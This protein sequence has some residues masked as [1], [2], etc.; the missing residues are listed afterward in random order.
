MGVVEGNFSAEGGAHSNAMRISNDRGGK[1]KY[2]VL[3]FVGP[4]VFG[5]VMTVFFGAGHPILL[6]VLFCLSV[7]L[8]FICYRKRVRESASEVEILGDSLFYTREGQQHEVHKHRIKDIADVGNSAPRVILIFLHD[9]Q[10]IEF[11]PNPDY[12][13]YFGG[14]FKKMFRSWLAAEDGWTW[15]V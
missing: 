9:G 4:L 12:G 11:F 15:K 3:Y 5:G 7:P 13:R 14:R 1:L 8:F 10:T 2:G 6:G